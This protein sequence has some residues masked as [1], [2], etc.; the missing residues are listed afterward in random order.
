MTRGVFWFC[1]APLVLLGLSGCQFSFEQREP[2]RAE[3]E[4]RCLAEGLVKSSAY[5]IPI[6]E[7][8]GAG[9]CG[10]DHPFKVSGL[11]EG[12]VAVTP[13][14]TLA[15]PVTA[16]LDRWMIESVQPAAMAWFGQPVVKIKQ[17]SAYSCRNMNGARTGKISEHAY[18]NALDIAAFTLA[19]G[20][21]VVVQTGWKGAPEEQGFLR[22]V[23]A[24]ACER[25]TTVL[26]PGS[27]IYHYN[28]IHVDLMRRTS[29]RGIC[30]PAPRVP[31]PPLGPP[32]ASQY[33]SQYPS[34]NPGMGSSYPPQAEPAAANGGPMEVSPEG[35]PGPSDYG[36]GVDPSYQP[37]PRRQQQPQPAGYPGGYDPGYLPPASMPSNG[38]PQQPYPA[39]SYPPQTP[40]YPPPSGPLPPAGVPLVKWQRGA[41]PLVTGSTRSY[42]PEPKPAAKKPF[43]FIAP[44]DRPEAVPGED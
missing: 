41:D 2:W 36:H 37:Q 6:R 29:G 38:Y 33:P 34:Q 26:A 16:S 22:T 11:A 28:H 35:E 27:N 32:M 7:I 23:Q 1:V 21:E 18:G 19:D 20:R 9:T 4:E 3:A 43:S 40:R 13:A 10:M 15:C 24:S 25:F 12:Q 17:I 5:T 30:Q 39:N 31:Q 14:A 44:I 8:D 42:A